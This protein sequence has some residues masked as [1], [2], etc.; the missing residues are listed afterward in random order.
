VD[1]WIKFTVPGKIIAL[2]LSLRR[3]LDDLLDEKI[4]KPELDL[5]RSN[6]LSTTVALLSSDGVD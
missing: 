1:G 6:V 3:K 4:S 2:I 5:S